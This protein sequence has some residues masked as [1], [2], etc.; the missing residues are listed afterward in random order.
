MG[1]RD[2]PGATPRQRQLKPNRVTPLDLDLDV[3]FD[4]EV[5]IPGTFGK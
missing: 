5:L 3:D 2:Q 1:W 4:Q